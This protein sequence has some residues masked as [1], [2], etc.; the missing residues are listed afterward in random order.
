MKFILPRLHIILERWRFN[1]DYQIYVSTLGHFKKADK[2][3][4]FVNTGDGNYLYVETVQGLRLAHRMVMIT[5][6]PIEN[7]D[8]ITVDHLD[9][10]PRNN[11]LYNLEWVTKRENIK[12]AKKD[13]I[14]D[15]KKTNGAKNTR[16]YY[17]I[18]LNRSF[19]DIDDLVMFLNKKVPYTK[20]VKE[21]MII[22]RI[23]YAIRN[24][25]KAFTYHWKKFV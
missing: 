15:K 20:S 11:T 24:K 22:E 3:P 23:N 5:W 13:H 10:N 8:N 25:T 18:E 4:L 19:D 1:E 2:S 12:R 17:C 9:H 16:H 21:D 14:K 6:R 7:A